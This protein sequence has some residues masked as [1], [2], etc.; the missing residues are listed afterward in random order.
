MLGNKVA[1]RK[2]RLSDPTHRQ[3]LWVS[4]SSWRLGKTGL[5]LLTSSDHSDM[6]WVALRAK[7]RFWGQDDC[8][9]T[10]DVHVQDHPKFWPCLSLTSDRLDPELP[11]VPHRWCSSADPQHRIPTVWCFGT[12]AYPYSTAVEGCLAYGSVLQHQY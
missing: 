7:T 4:F 9:C 11:D 10:T 2:T 12:L 8:R 5:G 3:L 6:A 1:D